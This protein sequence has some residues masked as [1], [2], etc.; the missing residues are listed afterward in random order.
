MNILL[1]HYSQDLP[2]PSQDIMN[3][4][5][6]VTLFIRI[7][8]FLPLKTRAQGQDLNP[9]PEFLWAAGPMDREPAHPY[10]SGIEPLQAD[11]KNVGPC[12]E[13]G[14]T[15]KIIAPNGRLITAPNGGTEATTISFMNL[16]STPVAN[17][18]LSP[19]RGISL[20]PNPMA[21][22]L[23]QVNQVAILR[24]L[25]NERTPR[26]SAIL[27]PLDPSTQFPQTCLSQCPDK[28]PMENIKFGGGVLY[29]P[30]DPALQTYHHF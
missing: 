5:Q 3:S 15:K 7:D 26:P 9:E 22:T 30:K 8:N 11:T 18:E 4:T 24:F 12:S 19:G 14:Q 21:T 28:P 23:R 29:R 27:L 16:K 17:Q 10:L 13:T 1:T 20:Q 25:T 6:H 2:N